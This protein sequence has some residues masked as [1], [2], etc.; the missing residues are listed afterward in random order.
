MR[1][2]GPGSLGPW[3]R[4]ASAG[5]RARTRTVA[6]DLQPNAPPFGARA[7]QKH[8]ARA[9][10]Y[11]RI[12]CGLK[13]PRARRLDSV[14]MGSVRSRQGERVARGRVGGVPVDPDPDLTDC[15]DGRV[16]RGT[17]VPRRAVLLFPDLGVGADA[18]GARVLADAA[19]HFRALRRTGAA[20]EDVHHEL[21]ARRRQADLRVVGSGPRGGRRSEGHREEGFLGVGCVRR[22]RV[23][24]RRG[25]LGDVTRSQ[26]PGEDGRCRRA[27]NLPSYTFYDNQTKQF[28][29]EVRLVSKPYEPGGLPFTWLVGF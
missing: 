20:R 18:R 13:A 5:G 21:T 14:G 8:D 16:R 4:G 9:L 15:R 19:R 11:S 10:S 17:R 26:R 22:R 12:A 7:P 1:G 29:Q 3:R 2:R 25:N 27:V 23:D 28:Q 6:V 24:Q